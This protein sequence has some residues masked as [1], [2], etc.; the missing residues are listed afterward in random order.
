M[1]TPTQPTP[2]PTSEA[3]QLAAIVRRAL[4]TSNHL[5]HLAHLA[6]DRNALLLQIQHTNPNYL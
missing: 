3:E 2:A 4:T 5:A 1:P 6:N